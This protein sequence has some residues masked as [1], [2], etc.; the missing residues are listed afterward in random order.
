L[1]WSASTDNI[2]V[3]GY[4]VKRNGNTVATVATLAYTDSGLTASTTYSY[5]VVAVDAA[6]NTSAPA[7]PLS[8]A[9]LAQKPGDL[10]GDGLVDLFDL[11]ILLSNWDDT[12]KPQYDLNSNGIVDI[13]DLS[14]L[15]T[16]Y[17]S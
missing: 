9:T 13:F 14:I 7:G 5:S 8:V 17:G 11:S 4:Q 12:N 1:A 16:N 2:G 6:G 10:N 15:L 3:T